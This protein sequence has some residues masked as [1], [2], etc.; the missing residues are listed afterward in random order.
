MRHQ[1]IESYQKDVMNLRTINYY[2][3]TIGM[4]TPFINVNKSEKVT[5]LMI[6]VKQELKVHTCNDKG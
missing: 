1:K 2:R 6:H 3:Y 5:H 4:R